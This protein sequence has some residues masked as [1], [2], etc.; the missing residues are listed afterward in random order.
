MDENMN[1]NEGEGH[2]N[3]GE[4]HENEADDEDAGTDI[5]VS[6]TEDPQV[7]VQEEGA[8]NEGA[9]N[10]GSANE[11]HMV[12]DDVNDE[13]SSMEDS[14]DLASSVL[15]NGVPVLDM[16]KIF[17]LDFVESLMSSFGL[18]D[19]NS[20]GLKKRK[21]NLD[22][23]KVALAQQQS[24]PQPQKNPSN[25][26]RSKRNDGHP[27]GISE[28]PSLGT[29]CHEVPRAHIEESYYIR[30]DPHSFGE[31]CEEDENAIN[32]ESTTSNRID[33]QLRV[34]CRS[35][36]HAAGSTEARYTCEKTKIAR[37]NTLWYYNLVEA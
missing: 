29:T 37:S 25:G 36:V 16:L 10:E 11:V 22:K 26:K 5:I 7:N 2:D 32:Q 20:N 23:L 19:R 34:H 3:E 21:N 28:E 6:D 14:D 4:G 9:A 17:F 13:W 18:L 24:Q 12:D 1:D 15:F 31:H 8:A 30:R 33:A 35:C 27:Y